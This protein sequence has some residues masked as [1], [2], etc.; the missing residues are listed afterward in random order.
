MSS[1][2]KVT[3]Y[4]GEVGTSGIKTVQ[5]WQLE[6]KGKFIA[7][8]SEEYV[9]NLFHEMCAELNNEGDRS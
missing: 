1:K 5:H 4:G 8:T 9:A 7:D 3:T 2:A 6:Y